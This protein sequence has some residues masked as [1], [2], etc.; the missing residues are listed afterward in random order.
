M[1]G[2]HHLELLG[3]EGY[4]FLANFLSEATTGLRRI[5]L[6]GR[7][8][9][10]SMV[11]VG[12]ARVYRGVL[13]LDDLGPLDLVELTGHIIRLLL[14]FLGFLLHH[15]AIVGLILAHVLLKTSFSKKLVDLVDFRY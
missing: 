3:S 5:S 4:P 2:Q 1:L 10:V 9:L 8:C 15:A 11:D 7:G 6:L 12:F 13:V 14:G